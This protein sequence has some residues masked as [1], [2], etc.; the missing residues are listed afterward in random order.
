MGFRDRLIPAKIDKSFLI[1]GHY[2]AGVCRNA[3]VARWSAAHD[4]FYHWRNKFGFTFVE[5]IGYWEEGHLYD[6]FIPVVDLG[7]E[8]FKAV[9]IPQEPS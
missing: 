8:P 7:P 6:E 4:R 2:Y 3:Q 1:D 9:D 5:S